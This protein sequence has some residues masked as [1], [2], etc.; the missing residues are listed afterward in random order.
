MTR[1]GNRCSV[2]RDSGTVGALRESSRRC[3]RPRTSRRR[4]ARRGDIIAAVHDVPRFW[5]LLHEDEIAS[6]ELAEQ[7]RRAALHRCSGAPFAYAVG[8]S[9]F[10]HLT[11][12]RGRA[13]ADSAAGDRAAGR[14]GARARAH[15]TRDRHRDRLGRDRPR[16]RE[17][18]T[19]RSRDR[20]RHLERR[21]RRGARERR[22]PRGR[23]HGARGVARGRA[24]GA[25]GGRAGAGAGEQSAVHCV[26]RGDGAPG[27]GARLGAPVCALQRVGRNGHNR[28]YHSRG[29]EMC[30]SQV[31]CW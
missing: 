4:S 5:A 1:E 31:D 30:W 12:R 27:V 16:A 14:R 10:R 20:D 18:G 28:E 6:A 25:R 21:D 3:S 22:A 29:T 11:L 8:R 13:R 26:R 24:A 2:A 7:C 9:A 17:R 23:A 19:L 15:R